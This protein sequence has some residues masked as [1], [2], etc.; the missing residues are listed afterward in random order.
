MKQLLKLVLVLCVISANA[1]EF[2]IGVISDFEQAPTLDAIINQ[3]IQEIDHTVGASRKVSLEITTYGISDLSSARS[4]YNQLTNQVDLILALGSVSAKG[5]STEKY[6]PKPVVALG[7]VDP[8]LQDIPYVNGTSGKKNFTY[9]WQ[10]QD[11]EKELKAFN[12]MCDF[13]HVV[14]LVDKKVSSTVN[15]V[16][17]ST[18]MDSLSATLDAKLYIIPIGDDIEHVINQLPQEIDAVY[19]TA[20]ISQKESR[21]RLLVNEF[22][23]RK[24]PTFTGST[25]LMD[26][27]VLGSMTSDNNL[28]Q[29]IRKLAITVDGIASGSSLSS[30]PVT[31]DTKENLHVNI[32]TARKIQL[33]IPFEVLFTATLV[34]G[35]KEAVKTYSFVEIAEKSLSSNLNIQISYQDIEL[36]KL[37]VKS[38]RSNLLPDLKAGLTASQINEERAN[39]AFNSPERSLS[40]DITLNQL[41]Y[42]EQTIAGLR[43]SQ[44]L[45][46]AQEYNTEAEVLGVLFDTYTVYLNVL[47]A[48]TNLLIQRENLLNTKKNKELASI[49]V[50]IGSS[51]NAD[52]YR[53]ES[54]VALANQSVIAATTALLSAKLQ[55][56]TF[57][58]NTL[59]SE[60]DVADVALEDD[61]FEAF[62]KGPLTEVVKTPKSL[63]VV[64]D[65]LVA[66]SKLQ[67]PNKKALLAN[68]NASNRRLTQNKRLLYV[69]TLAL[70]AQTS[71]VLG[72]GGVGSTIDAQ[73]MALGTTEFQDNSWFAGVSLSYPIFN[74]LN[75]KVAIQQ[76]KINLDQL[77]NSQTLLDQNLE[78]GVRT[79]ILNLLNASTNIR[80]SQEASESARKNF[81]LVQEN[82]KQ[83]Q[84]T[85]TQLI[86]AQQAAL[87]ARLGAALSV[88]EYIQTHLQLE[89]NVG[90]FTMLMPEEQLQD[91]NNRLQQYINNRN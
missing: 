88:Y 1:Q 14:V 52:L 33:S 55:L 80:F 79:S 66:E 10:T 62:Y 60:F 40:G 37:E 78:L 69:P 87:Q 31:L 57:L 24:I 8:T 85:I 47:T 9:I 90:A 71:Q 16:R 38:V 25:R 77:N 65:F 58:A 81:E 11:L 34:E 76:S 59:E 28:Q 49:R 15:S 91:F 19:F 74:G 12:E 17:G 70:Q 43:I 23:D 20:I 45:Q 53:W 5:I 67:N 51:N 75:R 82:Y 26:Y 73:T 30:M 18:L 72:R 32:A 54:E 46:K 21:L 27:G 36:S 3:M 42:S 84:V 2:K 48:K 39:A 56:N 50:N 22:N 61:L 6:L 89:F 64:S 4:S 68:I 13:N 41:I 83:G 35:D 29:V 86:D 44:Y 7:I 63:A